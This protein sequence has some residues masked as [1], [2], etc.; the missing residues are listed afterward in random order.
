MR[1]KRL[2]ID[3]KVAAPEWTGATDPRASISLEDLLRMRSGLDAAETGSGFDPA[4]RMLYGHAD[5]VAF[6]AQHTLKHDP[7]ATWEYTSA[8]TLILDRVLGDTVGGRAAGM[9]GFAQRELFAPL[10]MVD[11]TMEFDGAGVFIGSSYVS[12]IRALVRTIRR[13]LSERWHRAERTPVAP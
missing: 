6:A 4:T 5:M 10:G 1:Q 12:C 2:R 9:R 7:G 13:A 8:N 3:Q 11:V